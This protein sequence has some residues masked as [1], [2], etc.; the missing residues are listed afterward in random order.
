MNPTMV[1]RFSGRAYGGESR[2][3]CVFRGRNVPAYVGFQEKLLR[4]ES[5]DRQSIASRVLPPD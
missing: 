3:L 1:V 4:T 2:G 5:H